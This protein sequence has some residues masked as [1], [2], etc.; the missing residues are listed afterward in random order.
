MVGGERGWDSVCP[1]LGS[2]WPQDVH[3]SLTPGHHDSLMK[4]SFLFPWWA[5]SSLS[6]TLCALAL[7]MVS[8]HSSPPPRSHQHTF[9]QSTD[10]R[11]LASFPGFAVLIKSSGCLVTLREHSWHPARFPKADTSSPLTNLPKPCGRHLRSQ[12]LRFAA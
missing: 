2:S 10:L 12:E 5:L 11:K 9:P 6:P 3:P 8:F 7:W 4:K 1:F